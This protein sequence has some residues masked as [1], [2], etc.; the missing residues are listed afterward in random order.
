MLTSRSE[1]LLAQLDVLTEAG[2]LRRLSGAFARFIGTLGQDTA[3]LLA[4]C[5]LL[6]ELEGRGHSCMKL[7]DLSGAVGTQL[8][9]QPELWR[10][11]RDSVAGWPQDGAGWRKL[12]AASE[13]V[14]A[15]GDLDFDQPLVLDGERLYLRRYWR[16]EKLVAHAVRQRALGEVLAGDAS[17]DIAGIRRWLDVLFPHASRGG[18]PDWQKIACAVAVRGKLGI[19]TGGPAR[20]RPTR[21]RACWHCCLPLPAQAA[22][23]CAWRWPRRPARRLPAQAIHRYGAGRTGPESGRRTAAAR[24][25]RP[26][27]RRAYPA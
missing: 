7:A 19:I 5:V 6:A 20:A 22:T 26:H 21:W 8:G 18:G 17:A 27:G 12:L 16:D 1:A 9:W 24:T 11:L 14:W 2:H 10:G 23:T 25:G 13:Q 4:A 3:P 15:V